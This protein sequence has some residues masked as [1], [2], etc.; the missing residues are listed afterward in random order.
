LIYAGYIRQDGWRVNDKPM[1]SGGKWTALIKQTIGWLG[2]VILAAGLITAGYWLLFTTFMV[3]DDE[4]Y[5]LISLKN[6]AEHGA[7]YDKVYAQYGPFF[8]VAYDALHR[9][10]GFAWTSTNGRL[11]T[12]V[13]WGATAWICAMLVWR[14]T[15]S[16]GATAFTLAG[17][18]TY[19][20]VMIHEPGHPGGAVS[21]LVA[22]AAW[23]GAKRDIARRPA[24]AALVGAIGAALALI[25]INV[26]GLL[27]IAAA[28]W[29]AIHS[30]NTHR[31]RAGE[32]LAATVLALLP[33]FLMHSLLG[34]DW[35]RQFA[36]IASL[37][38]LGVL[39]A[40][41]TSR[42]SEASRREWLG[43]LGG[44][45]A[46]TLITL[47]TV[48]AR[49]TS[50][51]ALL[52]GVVLDPLRHP[53]VY[54][55]AFDWKPSALPIA[56]AGFVLIWW[57]QWRPASSYVL[58]NVVAARFLAATAFMLA[59]LQMLPISL[60]A[61]GM[62]YGIGLAGI[63]ALPMRRD[64]EGLSDARTRQWLALILVLQSLHAYP[65]AG[66]QINW[67]TFLWVP[68]LALATRDGWL[69]LT[70]TVVRSRH[71]VACAGAAGAFALGGF[72][73]GK[74]LQTGWNNRQAGE[75]L[76]LPGAE[77]IIIPDNP[78]LGLRL[79]A[80]NARVH[81]GVLLSLPGSYS[82]NLWTG[83]PTPT[84][85]NA[86]HWFSLLSSQQQREIIDCLR[87]DPRAVLVVQLDTLRYLIQHGFP[88][89][90]ELVDYLSREFQ[91]SFEIDG[92]AF[93]IHRDRTIAPLSTGTLASKANEP[94]DR[95]LELVLIAPDRAIATIQLWEIIGVNRIHRLTLSAA[96]AALA[97][98]PL[99]ETG[100]VI[101]ARQSSTWPAGA[102]PGITRISVDFHSALPLSGQL[103]AL[104]F[105]S[106][107]RRIAVARIV[108]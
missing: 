23:I 95:R 12:L 26:G 79:M 107:G 69:A 67:G 104:L 97:S 62:S 68:L 49:G 14:R 64:P 25:K 85:A 42:P 66:S 102:P 9:L 20:W 28:I 8:Y 36:M 72:M 11:L 1:T 80:E 29:L 86:T 13:Q 55:F 53:D 7:L 83:C 57:A 106:Q 75:P 4:G 37:G 17:V 84:L 81:A 38:G 52:S 31:R 5:V 45:A 39:L 61:F 105:D 3:Y 21:L 63:C 2:L 47:A 30:P 6:F 98:T 89:R 70:P 90:G 76:G 59:A 15:R 71:V 58:G 96:N 33:W 93:W 22:M 78:A 108:R 65:V 10:L 43:L 35:V 74:L 99:D 32:W 56:I 88:P 51:Y 54:F 50:L 41:R 82:L 18:F 100:R 87:A 40:A 44:M 77:S 48:L 92:Y 16:S 60:A 94:H 27:L 73:G 46:V 34:Q 101:G 24:P 103:L 91:R 19:L